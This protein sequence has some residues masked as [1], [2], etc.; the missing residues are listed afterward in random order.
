MMY[1]QESNGVCKYR[2]HQSSAVFTTESVKKK[3]VIA[4]TL[5]QIAVLCNYECF[6]CKV[7]GDWGI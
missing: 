4:D 2:R 7:R 3:Q 1:A 6:L 5:K